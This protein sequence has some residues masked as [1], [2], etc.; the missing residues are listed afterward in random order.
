MVHHLPV[1]FV[2]SLHSDGGFAANFDEVSGI[3]PGELVDGVCDNIEAFLLSLTDQHQ[4]P[5]LQLAAA[6]WNPFSSR[7]SIL[8][9]AI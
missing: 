5:L 4:F 9:V 2:H 7:S 1:I 8:T 3:L 6:L